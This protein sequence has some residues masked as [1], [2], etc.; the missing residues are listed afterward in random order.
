[1]DLDLKK[2]PLDILQTDEC[3]EY[4]KGLILHSPN[5]FRMDD[6]ISQSIGA[7][8][9]NICGGTTMVE[10][11][12]YALIDMQLKE[13]LAAWIKEQTDNVVYNNLSLLNVC[14]Q[15]AVITYMVISQY[16]STQRPLSNGLRCIG[17][18][19]YTFIKKK[20]WNDAV[21]DSAVNEML[22][23][24]FRR[25]EICRVY[26]LAFLMQVLFSGKKI[27]RFTPCEIQQIRNLTNELIT[28]AS[29]RITLDDSSNEHSGA[30]STPYIR[31]KL[32]NLF[33]REIDQSIDDY[34]Y[35]HLDEIYQ[36]VIESTS[37]A[38][39][40]LKNRIEVYYKEEKESEQKY[41]KEYGEDDE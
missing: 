18:T 9:L 32:P 5:G 25:S 33:E 40:N 8:I 30:S 11:A 34:V 3:K 39:N 31:A 17:R 12:M 13:D 41:K 28:N 19:L 10:R 22:R 27:G 21:V 6:A 4:L 15:N 23:D 38:L 2:Y 7:F 16:I 37:P 14:R 29:T 26:N 1:M 20:N 35:H 24:D 36:D